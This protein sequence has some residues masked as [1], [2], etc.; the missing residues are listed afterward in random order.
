LLISRK[1]FE[2][3]IRAAGK[4][5]P[6]FELKDILKILELMFKDQLD[7][8]ILFTCDLISFE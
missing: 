8:K 3:E 5:M 4:M 1:E 7:K 6:I 2:N